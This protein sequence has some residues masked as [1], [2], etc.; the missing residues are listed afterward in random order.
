MMFRSVTMTTIASVLSVSLACGVMA[1]PYETSFTV[2]DAAISEPNS[3]QLH[4]PSRGPTSLWSD[5]ST[6]CGATFCNEA[7]TAPHG[8]GPLLPSLILDRSDCY[9][10]TFT[11]DAL[12]LNRSGQE[13]RD[14]VFD[15][16]GNAVLNSSNLDFGV[17][18]GPRASLLLGGRVSGLEFALFGFNKHGGTTRVSQ[19]GVVPVF[20]NAIPADPVNTYDIVSSAKLY[21]FESNF[22]FA[23]HRRVRLGGGLR[24]L[25]LSG[26]FDVLFTPIPGR[27]GFFGSA[28]NNLYGGQL[29]AG[30]TVLE[31]GKLAV[32]LTAKWGVYNNNFI[33]DAVTLN[34][35]LHEK[36]DKDA[37][38]TELN[39]GFDYFISRHLSFRAGYAIYWFKNVGLAFEQSDNFNVFTETGTF[40]YDSPI[41]QGG[42][43][44][45]QFRW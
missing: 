14:F 40:D 29:V 31:L 8:G 21:S 16:M 2:G 44:G 3:T 45:L 18:G 19:G 35:E 28:E 12:F 1:E 5:P 13:S 25:E 7:Q 36:D 20:F 4:A 33:I 22:W 15:D 27:S 43:F 41:Y 30:V 42:Y 10:V 38:L 6:P 11:L 17:Q 24:W 37:Y 32:D 39:V 23:P 9:E 34:E 26:V